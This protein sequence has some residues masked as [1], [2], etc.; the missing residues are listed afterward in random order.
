MHLILL[1]HTVCDGIHCKTCLRRPLKKK[2]KNGFSRPIIA[3][4][5]SKVL[6]NARFNTPSFVFKT[7]DFSMFEWPLKTCFNVKI[8]NDTERAFPMTPSMCTKNKKGIT[9]LNEI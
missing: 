9:K 8:L 5:R 4:C 6:Q 2:T 7:F 1:T 3:K